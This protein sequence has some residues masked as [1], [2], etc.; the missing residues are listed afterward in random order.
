MK[1]RKPV[2]Y[3]H[4][5][6]LMGVNNIPRIIKDLK[7]PSENIILPEK[8]RFISSEEMNLLFNCFD[9]H[10]LF[11]LQEG[12]SWTVVEAK[13]TGTP[14]LLSYT[15]AHEDFEDYS[16]LFAEPDHWSFLALM[17]GEGPIYLPVPCCSETVIKNIFIES[18][19]IVAEYYGLMS[20]SA[21][22]FGR[23]WCNTTHHISSILKTEPK[24]NPNTIEGEII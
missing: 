9:Y 2:L 3:I 6:R 4:T 13:L 21:I 23:N 16:S 8:N 10:V 19:G 5:D 24:T 12:L 22:K 15:T 14:S 18:A 20:E 11:S 7:I 17:T 1:D